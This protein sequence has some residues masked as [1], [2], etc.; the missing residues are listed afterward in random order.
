MTD[1]DL[2]FLPEQ[3]AQVGSDLGRDGGALEELEQRLADLDSSLS[4]AWAGEAW[5]RY[6]RRL[7]AARQRT[8]RLAQRLNELSSQLQTVSGIYREGESKARAAQ[9]GLPV[10]GIFN[11]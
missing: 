10:E 1:R 5:E 6:R 8:G 11:V 2:L 7:A 4:D 9:D 3:I